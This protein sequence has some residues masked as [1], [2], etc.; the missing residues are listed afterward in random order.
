[1]LHRLKYSCFFTQS[2]LPSGFELNSLAVVWRNQLRNYLII[3]Q[4]SLLSHFL[5]RVIVSA[6]VTSLLPTNSVCMA[7]GWR[8][9]KAWMPLAS[10]PGLPAPVFDRLQ[11][12]EG[13]GTR[14]GWPLVFYTCS[15]DI[16]R[17]AITKRKPAMAKIHDG[18]L[19]TKLISGKSIDI[20]KN[21]FIGR[22]FQLCSKTL[23]AKTI[24]L[25]TRL[26]ISWSQW[27]Q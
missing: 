17:A 3:K 14:L 15:D 23:Q 10:F 7:L 2:L 21:N 26:T 4:E 5:P 16:P 19:T 22:P 24:T 11:L 6:S 8:R 9:G 13:L 12:W 25:R 20:P 1:M 27:D 18:L